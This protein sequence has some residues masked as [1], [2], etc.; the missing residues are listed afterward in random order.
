MMHG[1]ALTVLVPVSDVATLASSWTS[2]SSRFA[3][4][5]A[6]KSQ[7]RIRRAVDLHSISDI[8]VVILFGVTWIS[9][10]QP[11]ITISPRIQPALIP[12]ELDPKLMQLKGHSSTASMFE[13]A[14]LLL[15]HTWF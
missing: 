1:F 8:G 9:H 5:Q 11:Q 14:S 6:L 10:L 2:C 3:R 15:H 4:H 13:K 12:V 7:F